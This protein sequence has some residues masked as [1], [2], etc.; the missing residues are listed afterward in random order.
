[1]WLHLKGYWLVGRAQVKGHQRNSHLVLES[2]LGRGD[3]HHRRY[4]VK[5][6][7]PVSPTPPKSRLPDT[8]ARPP[9]SLSLS[10]GAY[11]SG[12]LRVR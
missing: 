2:S 11:E 7:V 8:G 12:D 4:L 3:H 6:H 5:V 10:L 9:S 1:M